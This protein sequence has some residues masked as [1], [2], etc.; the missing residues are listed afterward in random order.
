M[1]RASAAIEHADL[2]SAAHAQAMKSSDR[3]SARARA[4]VHRVTPAS[5][6]RCRAP[7]VAAKARPLAHAHQ[8]PNA[9]SREG[10]SSSGRTRGRPRFPTRNPL[11]Q[12]AS[13]NRSAG[14]SSSPAPPLPGELRLVAGFAEIKAAVAAPLVA[15]GRCVRRAAAVARI[16]H[17]LP[18]VAS[19]LVERSYGLPN[20][21]P[22]GSRHVHCPV[23]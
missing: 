1:A 21:L 2:L 14:N 16:L 3:V 15:C 19:T 12:V 22:I 23:I 13:Q 18:R 11:L 4:L 8:A 10:G 5:R 9:S 6:A 17:A 7:A 20:D